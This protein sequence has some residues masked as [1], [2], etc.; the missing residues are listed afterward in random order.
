MIGASLAAPNRESLSVALDQAGSRIEAATIDSSNFE[1][2][3]RLDKIRESYLATKPRAAHRAFIIDDQAEVD[4]LALPC[5]GNLAAHF[6]TVKP[7]S[8]LNLK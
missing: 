4:R 7:M 6:M 8:G 2:I 5:C 3:V 1:W